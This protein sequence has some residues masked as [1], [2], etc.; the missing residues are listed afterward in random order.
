M[1]AAHLDADLNIGTELVEVRTGDRGVRP[2]KRNGRQAKGTRE[3]VGIEIRQIIEDC[4]GEKGKVWRENAQA[5]KVK[6]A[7][8]WLDGGDSKEDFK[9]FL[10]Q[11]GF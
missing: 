10:T 2:L 11:Y 3:A 1:G 9:A 7:K 8:V 4:R 5:M 6:F